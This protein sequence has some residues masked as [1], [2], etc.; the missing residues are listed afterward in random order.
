[1][2]AP[3]AS[4]KDALAAVRASRKPPVKP[5]SRGP[6]GLGNRNSADM[7]LLDRWFSDW[8]QWRRD[9][10]SGVW[11]W[12][13]TWIAI[14][15]KT[16]N[17]A[18]ASFIRVVLDARRSAEASVNRKFGVS[19]SAKTSLLNMS[20]RRAH[21][22]G[23]LSGLAAE[24]DVIWPVLREQLITRLPKRAPQFQI[25][26]AL[27]EAYH[28]VRDYHRFPNQVD[29]PLSRQ[30]PHQNRKRDAF[31]A[32]MAD[33]FQKHCGQEHHRLIARLTEIAFPGKEIETDTVMYAL[34]RRKRLK[35]QAHAR[36]R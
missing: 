12:E 20:N 30:G 31:Y 23:H 35:K 10:E 32:I 15:R 29:F 26:T 19:S 13:T 27:G 24:W 8:Q 3:A 34:R 18:P 21:L 33:W 17:L 22:R 6:L 28:L 9:T 14:K 36:R 4:F 2:R 25:E 16:P 11:P 5:G 7:Q 1:M